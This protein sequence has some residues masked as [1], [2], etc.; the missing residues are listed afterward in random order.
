V[1]RAG[2]ALAESAG[3]IVGLYHTVTV[4]GADRATWTTHVLG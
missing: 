1:P 4:L 3:G 2:L